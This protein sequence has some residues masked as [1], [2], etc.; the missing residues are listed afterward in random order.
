MGTLHAL[1]TPVQ[2]RSQNVFKPE[3]VAFLSKDKDVRDAD[4]DVRGWD[5]TAVAMELGGRGVLKTRT[6]APAS[7]R[8]FSHLPFVPGAGSGGL[9]QVSEGDLPNSD[10]VDAPK[11]GELVS[12]LQERLGSGRT[13]PAFTAAPKLCLTQRIHY[14]GLA[15]LHFPHFVCRATSVTSSGVKHKRQPAIWTY[16]D[17]NLETELM[18][19]LPSRPGRSSCGRA[20]SDA[21][22]RREYTSENWVSR[23]SSVIADFLHIL[24]THQHP[25]WRVTGG[26]PGD[27]TLAASR[28]GEESDDIFRLSGVV[29]EDIQSTA[30]AA[31]LGSFA[32][33]I[34]FISAERKLEG[35]FRM[36]ATILDSTAT[37]D[38]SPAAIPQTIVCER[39]SEFL[40]QQPPC[41]IRHSR[42]LRLSGEDAHRGFMALLIGMLLPAEAV[43]YPSFDTQSPQWRF[44]K[45]LRAPLPIGWR[46][47]DETEGNAGDPKRLRQDEGKQAEA[48]SDAHG[49]GISL[50]LG[51]YLIVEYPG[52]GATRCTVWGVDDALERLKSCEPTS[53]AFFPSQPEPPTLALMEP[54][55]SQRPGTVWAGVVGG[56]RVIFKR[57][58]A[59]KYDKLATGLGAY[60][61]LAA[62]RPKVAS[63]PHWHARFGTLWHAVWPL[64]VCVALA[65]D[66]GKLL[67]IG[68]IGHIYGPLDCSWMALVTQDEGPSVASRG[69]FAA[70]PWHNMSAHFPQSQCNGHTDILQ[71]RPLQNPRSYTRR[72]CQARRCRQPQLVVTRSGDLCVVDFGEATLDHFCGGVYCPELVR[73]RRIMEGEGTE[74][75]EEESEVTSSRS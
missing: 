32:E 26:V 28:C 7:H 43:P 55:E 2:R 64:S 68:R 65:D 56:R 62:L 39:F 21:S 53:A 69:G 17:R 50:Q 71:D 12:K 3:L 51:S 41:V 8:L 49:V 1:L 10:V 46:S 5:R 30:F 20:L 57:Y 58:D 14:A 29:E 24:I 37:P 47:S 74:E 42:I 19:P 33:G 11:D 60:Q 75:E 15:N 16:P 23:L 31:Q 59:A 13:T 70:I 54:L 48:V 67:N 38:S 4:G 66:S 40:D 45:K 61:R 36:W 6:H 35:V 27:T 18:N 72:R 63:D 34:N 52:G 25:A 73:F 9:R 22:E 44:S